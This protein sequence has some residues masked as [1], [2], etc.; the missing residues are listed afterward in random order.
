VL[1]ADVVYI[2]AA[3]RGDGIGAPSHHTEAA[4]MDSSPLSSNTV[5]VRLFPDADGPPADLLDPALVFDALGY[6]QH[7]GLRPYLERLFEVVAA[8]GEALA[9][10]LQSG[11]VLIRRVLGERR[12]AHVSVL[13][14]AETIETDDLAAAGLAPEP[15]AEGLFVKVR[16]CDRGPA[17]AA[18]MARRLADTGGV[19]APDQLVLRAREDAEPGEHS[20]TERDGK[21]APTTFALGGFAPNAAPLPLQPSSAAAPAPEQASSD[22]WKDW[23][24]FRYTAPAR[25]RELAPALLARL[26]DLDEAIE[27]GPEF[28]A[29]LSQTGLADLAS[30]ALERVESAWRRRH[31][32]DPNFPSDAAGGRY[33]VGAA[34]A[35]V[36][37]DRHEEA[38]SLF[39]HVFLLLQMQLDRA[40]PRRAADRTDP[41]QSRIINVTRL[42]TYA[43]V[44]GIYDEMRRIL[45]FYFALARKLE[46]AGDAA[47]AGRARAAGRRLRDTIRSE[48]LLEGAEAMIA[49]VSQVDTASGPALRIHG[50]NQADIEVTQLPGLPTPAE[51][52]PNPYQAK[53]M[54]SIHAALERQAELID[55]LLR[56]PAIRKGF[57][58]GY[59]DMTKL[60]DRLLVWRTMYRVYRSGHDPLQ[61]LMGL[62]GRYLRAFT[63]HTEYN[64]R[65]WGVSYLEADERGDMPVDLAGRAERDCGV[66]ALAA[67]YELYRTARSASPRLELD[68]QLVTTL[69]HAMLVITEVPG[70]F[71]IVSNDK[72]A[73]PRTG[74][75]ASELGKF[76]AEERGRR[77]GVM[78]AMTFEL[79]ATVEKKTKRMFGKDHAWKTYTR[80]QFGLGRPGEDKEPYY[81]QYYTDQ[82]AIDDLSL[83]LIAA[84]ANRRRRT[85]GD[86][87]AAIA[88]RLEPLRPEYTR[89]AFLWETWGTGKH[90]RRESAKHGL[91][92]ATGPQPLPRVAKMLLRLRRL[93]GTLDPRDEKVLEVCNSIPLIKQKV[94]AYRKAGMP[95]TF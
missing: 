9:G 39:G 37:D 66:Y 1:A 3:A 26:I 2:P 5:L 67:A 74:D 6:G 84:L 69:D 15:A 59:I 21:I 70:R 73:G 31:A 24:Y 85:R 11:D 62:F 48:F 19:L 83:D 50:A 8:P 16:E 68:F 92:L 23:S 18:R 72:V 71:Y 27:H 36:R 44:K 86:E 54:K 14:S 28:A 13:A 65:D 75:L 79:G 55:K 82:Q 53:P 49:E 25:A 87:R 46:R 93:G 45:A 34:E 35:A 20:G 51:I 47:G 94:D 60:S 77:A 81:Q 7:A 17:G 10:P 64:I 89:L 40:G 42:V 58:T 33:L 52:G 91:V 57:P 32:A 22:S 29:W 88:A 41:K 12:L 61:S 4:P 80:A 38:I 43:G 63:V 78:P 76:A 30:R 95:A 90:W 56:V